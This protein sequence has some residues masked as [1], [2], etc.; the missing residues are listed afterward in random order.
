MVRWAP[1]RDAVSMQRAMDA[2]FAPAVRPWGWAE[3][4]SGGSLPVDV[5]ENET[6]YMVRASV[7]GVK[8]E[9]LNVTVEN[10]VLKVEAKMASEEQVEGARYHVRERRSGSF[11]R[12]IRFAADVDAANVTAEYANGVLSL[13]LPKRE[14][15]K[16]MR[17]AVGSAQPALPAEAAGEN[18]TASA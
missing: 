1:Y 6:G 12:Q 7:P 17:I 11:A 5:S 15:A 3:G 2:M 8:P 9:D 14:E 13:T 10:N 16:P 4:W 18:E